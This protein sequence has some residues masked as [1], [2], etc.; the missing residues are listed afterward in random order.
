MKKVIIISCMMV[1][2]SSSLVF[3]QSEKKGTIMGTLGMG[4]AFRTTVELETL[5]SV[6]FDISL[7]SKPGLALCYTDV[8]VFSSAGTSRYIMPGAGYDYIR[9][10]W[11]IG[12]TLRNQ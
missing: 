8:T 5:G 7:I 12:V 10:K 1:L 4:V 9:E 2:L 11:H 3:S 6:I